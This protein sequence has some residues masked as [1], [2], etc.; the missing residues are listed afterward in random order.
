MDYTEKNDGYNM[1]PSHRKEGKLHRGF[2]VLDLSR[3]LNDKKTGEKI[4]AEFLDVRFYYPGE[5]CYCCF[6]INLP[7]KVISGSAKAGGYGYEKIT[8]AFASALHN[9]GFSEYKPFSASG[10]FITI[11]DE[12]TEFFG[13]KEFTKVEYYA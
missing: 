4:I 11:I 3:I 8:A 6:W 13:V 12:L 7:D 5:T 9:A 1:K 10:S 2:K